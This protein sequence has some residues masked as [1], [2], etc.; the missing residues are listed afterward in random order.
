MAVRLIRQAHP[1]NVMQHQ[2]DLVP[3]RAITVEEA[4]VKMA[5]ICIIVPEVVQIQ[6]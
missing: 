1:I 6:L 3:D 4:W 2:A 5:T